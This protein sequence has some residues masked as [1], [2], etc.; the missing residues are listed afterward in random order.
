[1]QVSRSSWLEV[2][3]NIHLPIVK[4]I[5][6]WLYNSVLLRPVGLSSYFLLF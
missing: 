1:M 5:E 4:Y 2:P 6:S 3:R